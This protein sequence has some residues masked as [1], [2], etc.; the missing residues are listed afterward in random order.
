MTLD[1]LIEELQAAARQIGADP[2]HIE[3]EVVDT[4]D[5]RHYYPEMSCVVAEGLRIRIETR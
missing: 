2:R 5:D 1:R 3:V 4:E